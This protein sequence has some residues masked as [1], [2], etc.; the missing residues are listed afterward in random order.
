MFKTRKTEAALSY[1]A[2]LIF[3]N[4][5]NVESIEQKFSEPGYSRVQKYTQFFK[6][7]EIF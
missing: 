4:Y 7:N 6:E 3:E 2:Y 1:M 5:R